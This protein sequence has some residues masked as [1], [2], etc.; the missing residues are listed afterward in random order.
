MLNNSSHTRNLRWTLNCLVGITNL[1]LGRSI[2][3]SS[4]DFMNQPE[5]VVS[6]IL[7]TS[8]INISVYFFH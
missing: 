6:G 4:Y 2:G 3:T 7:Y 8:I 1:L 5:L